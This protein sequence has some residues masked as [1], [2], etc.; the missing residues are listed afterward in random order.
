MSFIFAL[1][2]I[3][4]PICIF[5]SLINPNIFKRFFKE[6]TSRKYNI[7]IFSI[8]F[9]VSFVLI[10]ITADNNN[11]NNNLNNESKE[12]KIESPEKEKIETANVENEIKKDETFK[13][14]IDNDNKNTEKKDEEIEE[15]IKQRSENENFSDLYEVVDVVD[16]DTISVIIEGKIEKLRLIGI[17]TPETVDPRKSVQ[18]F[19]K[20]A[21]DK[22]KELLS[23]K[24]VFLEKDNSQGERDKYNRLLKYVIL[25]DKTNFNKKMIEEGFAHEYTYNIPYK[26]QEEFKRAEKEARENKKGLWAENTCNGNTNKSVENTQKNENLDTNTNKTKSLTEN[27]E[28]YTCDCKKACTKMTFEEA[29]FQLKKCGCTAR[30]RDKDGI[31]CEKNKIIF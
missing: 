29:Q 1:L 11:S 3:I 14:V 8:L 4:S 12:V 6:K 30:D 17:D 13:E 20:E 26:Y 2:F 21:S 16:G 9:V 10:G 31:A 24:K 19:G 27:E 28:K 15:H 22:A 18:C 7:K 25:E 5:L 23:G